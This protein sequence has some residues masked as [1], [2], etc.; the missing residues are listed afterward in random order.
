LGNQDR[1]EKNP[2]GS[3]LKVEAENIRYHVDEAT[4]NEGGD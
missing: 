1:E 4:E 2:R 3:R